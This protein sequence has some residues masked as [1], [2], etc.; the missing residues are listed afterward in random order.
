MRRIAQRPPDLPRSGTSPAA[1][2]ATPQPHAALFTGPQSLRVSGEQRAFWLCLL[3]APL[4]IGLIGLLLKSVTVSDVLLL[5]V[6]G[7]AYVSISRGRLLGSSIRIHERQFHDVHA[8]VASTAAHLGIA[9]PQIFVRDDVFVPIAA[10][11]IGE[12]YA[13]ILSS[14]YLEHL[15]PNEIRFLVARELGHIAAGHTRL[16]SLLSASGRENPAVALIFG[17]WLR[18]TEYT[19]DRVGLLCTESLADAVSAISITTFHA[20]GRRVDMKVLAEQRREIE[21]EPSLRMGEWI[22]GAPYATNRIAA[23]AEFAGGAL[24][25]YWL[26]ELQGRR[27]A[28]HAEPLE[29]SGS[30]ERTDLA[31]NWRRALALFIDVTVLGLILHTAIGFGLN[32]DSTPKPKVH[33]SDTALLR[34]FEAHNI[35]VTMPSQSFET[36]LAFLIYAAVLVTLSGQ[37]LGMMIA[38]L[39]VV[40][41]RFGS[42]GIA[43]ALWRY[44]VATF[45]LVVL[46]VALLGLVTRVHL[47]DRLS[48]TRLVRGRSLPAPSPE[49]S[50]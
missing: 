34:F 39:R 45:A 14:Q 44:M 35:N 32:D 12:P 5:I 17:A 22:G 9:S 18:R 27:V 43:R 29:R 31:P 28:V 11:G 1:P 13:L 41:L 24:H 50:G 42:V 10:V 16:T 21:A 48:G 25:H 4:T 8:I 36:T 15:R 20:I 2:A 47:H 37:T 49:R 23:L 7:M 33:P 3:S 6:A 40:T 26:G 38:D 30:V 19:A 46:P